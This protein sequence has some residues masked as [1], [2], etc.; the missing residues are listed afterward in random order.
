[1]GAFTYEEYSEDDEDIKE[2]DMKPT[3]NFDFSEE[4][5][6]E[7]VFAYQVARFTKSNAIVISTNFQTIGIAGGFTS[8]VDAT[9]FAIKKQKNLYQER[10]IMFHKR[11]L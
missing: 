1:M 2:E 8:R 7:L 9:E 11:F 10:I 3:W 5:I 4:E 6:K